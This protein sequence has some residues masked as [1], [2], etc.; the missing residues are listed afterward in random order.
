LKFDQTALVFGMLAN[1]F[2]A[3]KGNENSKLMKD[4]KGDPTETYKRYGGVGNQFAVTTVLR[5]GWGSFSF[6]FDFFFDFCFPVFVGMNCQIDYYWCLISFAFF[7]SLT[8]FICFCNP[9]LSLCQSL[10]VHLQDY[11]IPGLLTCDVV[12]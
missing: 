12:H 11:F 4:L 9:P 5:R 6:F 3:F 7:F 2:A 10:S 1:I 8:R